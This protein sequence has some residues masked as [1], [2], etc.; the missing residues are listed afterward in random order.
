MSKTFLELLEDLKKTIDLEQKTAIT[1]QLSLALEEDEKYAERLLQ[2]FFAHALGREVGQGFQEI[3]KSDFYNTR[4]KAY[5]D[6]DFSVK[7]AVGVSYLQ[8]SNNPIDNL[9]SKVINTLFEELIQNNL[10]LLINDISVNELQLRNGELLSA[11][12]YN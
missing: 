3:I 7:I 2:F 4:V 12:N 11:E 1:R 10:D 6:E 9:D 5:L 8:D